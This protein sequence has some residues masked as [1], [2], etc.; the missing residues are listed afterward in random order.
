MEITWIYFFYIFI[1]SNMF[2]IIEMLQHIYLCFKYSSLS[3]SLYIYSFSRMKIEKIAYLFGAKYENF[4]YV[5]WFQIDSLP[6]STFIYLYM[7]HVVKMERARQREWHLKVNEWMNEWMNEWK[8]K[9]DGID[10]DGIAIFWFQNS[11]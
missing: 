7:K 5:W 1:C 8:C 10:K 3:L 11:K 2:V 6:F 9:A 4:L